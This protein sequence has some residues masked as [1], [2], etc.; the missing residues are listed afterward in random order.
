[1]S[2][3]TVYRKGA[4]V[5]RMY[6]TLLTVEGFNKGM[7][8]YFERHD[9]DAVTCDDFLAAMADANGK[10][11]RQFALWYSTPGTPIVSFSYTYA[12]GVFSLTLSQSSKSD[13]P[14]HIPVCVGLLDKK[15]CQ[16][17][18]PTRVLE[19]TEMKQTFTF[20]DLKGE[21]VPSLL[22]NFSAPIKLVPD[23]NEEE[24]VAFLAAHDTDGFNRWHAGQKLFTAL[25]FEHLNR[26]VSEKTKEFVHGAFSRTLMDKESTDFSVQA[27]AL[28]LPTKSTLMEDMKVIDP[29]GIHEARTA[30]KKDIARRHEKDL[31]AR[32]E[33]LTAIMKGATY[34][35]DAASNGRRRLRNIIL[36]YLCTIQE[37]PEEQEAAAALASGHF[38]AATCMSD[39]IAAF[40]CLASMEGKGASARDSAVQKFYEYA[41][42]DALILDKWFM[43]QA[44]ADLPDVL[45]RVKQLMKH[46]DF[47]ILNPNKCRA[48]ISA[49]TM[50][51]VAFH[52][53]DGS[54]YEFLGDI[55]VE[56]DKVNGQMSSR[57][58]GKLIQWKRFDNK[59]ADL[60]KAQLKRLGA[61]KLSPNLYE[62]VNRGLK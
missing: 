22:R 44:L 52:A 42:G 50:N 56:L 29:I 4:E 45:D 18:V 43:V 13:K 3:G 54:G 34:T 55:L 46:N 61:M 40:N 60:M 15:T 62:I 6:Q 25:I 30:V 28:T 10:D 53:E 1:M 2:Y 19:L 57:F 33:E 35:V 11:L 31:R 58:A 9:G 12:N 26:N 48:L 23:G 39:K 24:S 41:D 20:G 27:Y 32:Y 21:V 16:E 59:R 51:T 8:L 7:K 47:N 14:L 37:T 17:V 36:D 49:F 5:I 38:E